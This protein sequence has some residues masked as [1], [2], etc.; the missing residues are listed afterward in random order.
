LAI[1]ENLLAAGWAVSVG[2]RGQRDQPAQLADRRVRYVALDRDKPGDLARALGDGADALIDITAYG[3]GH[4]RQLLDVQSSVGALVTVSSSSV[5][6]DGEG[7]TL[8]EAA[9]NGF[10]ELPDPIAETQPTVAPGDATYSTRKV[11]LEHLLL[12]QAT[13]PVT[14]LRPVVSHVV[15]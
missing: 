2:S 14:I 9:Q 12:D 7:R 15:V 4:G 11:A 1:T 10:P 3:A 6:R 13:I 8:D 5:Y